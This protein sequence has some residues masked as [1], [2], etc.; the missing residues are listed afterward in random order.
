MTLKEIDDIELKL[1]NIKYDY[2]ELLRLHK[3]FSGN[4]IPKFISASCLEFSNFAIPESIGRKIQELIKEELDK[5][6]EEIQSMEIEITGKNE[7]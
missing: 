2:N 7:Q 5:K 1:H 4:T 3:N 6:H